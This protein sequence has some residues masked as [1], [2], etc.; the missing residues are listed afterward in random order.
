MRKQA[1]P[2]A[3]EK[4]EFARLVDRG[5]RAYQ[6]AYQLRLLGIASEYI[7]NEVGIGKSTLD[8]WRRNRI[9]QDYAVLQRFAAVCVTAAPDLGEV[10]VTDLFRA[11]G[12]AGYRE[13]AIA[14]IFAQPETRVPPSVSSPAEPDTT[15]ALPPLGALPILPDYYIPREVKFQQL[16][17]A[18]L[19]RR[20][21]GGWVALIGMTGVGKSTLLAA[22]GHAPAIQTA[23]SNGVRWFECKRTTNAL[24]LAR[25]VALA[26]GKTF[27]QE[28][29][30]VDDARVALR[31]ALQGES[32]LLL[33]DNLIDPLP[34]RVLRHL[35]P[36]IVIVLTTRLLP[37]A[38]GLRVPEEAWIVL[39]AL[40]DSQAW[41]LIHRICAITPEQEPAVQQLLA[42]VDYHAFTTAIVAC[43]SLTLQMT[44]D[45]LL[46]AF[47]S[48]EVR[49]Q[50]LQ[51]LH[52]AQLQV[53]AS[54]EVDWQRLESLPRYALESL[55]RLPFFSWYDT[56]LGQAVW[57]VSAGGA[58][59]IWRTLHAMQLVKA[60]GGVPGCYSVHWLVW[61]F[62]QQKAQHWS[63]WQRLRFAVWP[64]RYPLRLPLP[65]WRAAIP[66][67]AEAPAWPWWSPVVP[68]TEGQRG[69]RSL[70]GWLSQMLWRRE[71][72]GVRLRVGP[73]EWVIAE[74]L[75]VRFI[76]VVMLGFLGALGYSLLHASD[77]LVQPGWCA[78]LLLPLG[79]A[80]LTYRDLRR[81][82]Q[83]WHLEV[84]FLDALPDNRCAPQ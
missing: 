77:L 54:L 4:P 30:T 60:T 51:T 66:C 39:N 47:Q 67:P 1:A 12:M 20:E 83:W 78:V 23:F 8:S 33:L 75:T 36:G 52:P 34:F 49:G 38:T 48:A 22:L 50:V 44:W 84:S 32:V 55:G 21:S 26:L 11:A 25:N 13:Q 16:Q 56:A 17:D 18:V 68:G 24:T 43:T 74:R 59:A 29:E 3:A 10:W 41:T 2:P 9:P 45:E 35:G 63:W 62:A 57:Q 6:H 65:W 61:D 58:T 19:A 69:W 71:E 15:P 46:A 28:I 70:L 80:L 5:V 37:V 82:V 40:T 73:E 64:W 53:W 79:L 14:D 76:A 27:P 81:I 42:A 72:D 7:A 31:Q